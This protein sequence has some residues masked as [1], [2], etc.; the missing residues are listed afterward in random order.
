M[1]L[2][3]PNSTPTTPTP[4]TPTPTLPLK[5]TISGFFSR[6]EWLGHF[7]ERTLL[8]LVVFGAIAY[9]IFWAYT[10]A[11]PWLLGAFTFAVTYGVFGNK[12][13]RK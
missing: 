5:G 4:T 9:A 12:K 6:H 11:L 8:G 2:V 7:L 10:H 3:E 13:R 1:T